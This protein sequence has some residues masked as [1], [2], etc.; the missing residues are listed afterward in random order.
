MRQLLTQINVCRL[1][2]KRSHLKF[3]L[4]FIS[5][6]KIKLKNMLKTWVPQGMSTNFYALYLHS[7]FGEE[8]S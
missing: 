7:A 8:I 5:V 2:L 6:L 3:F 1:N 4:P